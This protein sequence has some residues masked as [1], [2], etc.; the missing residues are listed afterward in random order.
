MLKKTMRTRENLMISFIIVFLLC[1]WAFL[2]F[3]KTKKLPMLLAG[4]IVLLLQLP[5]WPLFLP[6]K[7][8]F[9]LIAFFFSGCCFYEFYQKRKEKNFYIYAIMFLMFG[10]IFF[11]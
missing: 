3:Y 5:H 9:G 10:L 7:L 4:V 1:G 6:H 8:S 11:T 2:K